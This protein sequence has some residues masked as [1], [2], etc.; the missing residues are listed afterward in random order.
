MKELTKVFDGN[1]LRVDM[2]NDKEFYIDVT[3]IARKYGKDITGWIRSK[4]TVEYMSELLTENPARTLIKTEARGSTKIHNKMLIPFARFISAKFAVWADNMI[5]DIITGNL[6][7]KYQCE[8]QEALA[9]SRACNVYVKNGVKFTSC[10]GLLQNVP[11][12]AN[13]Y[14]E[15]S[16]KDLLFAKGLI[17][18]IYQQTKRWRITDKGKKTDLFDLDSHGTILYNI[19]NTTK[20]INQLVIAESIRENSQIKKISVY[21][22]FTGDFYC[23]FDSLNEAERQLGVTGI[24]GVLNGKRQKKH[25]RGMV[26]RDDEPKDKIKPLSGDDLKKIF[27]DINV[28]KNGIFIK[29]CKTLK[30]AGSI[31]GNG[32]TQVKRLIDSGKANQ[33]GYTYAYANLEFSRR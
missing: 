7:D 30:E 14:D 25:I 5:Y 16:I 13:K 2:I 31:G 19:D 33:S 20:A 4:G 10:K 11:E 22:G 27:R 8:M 3:G 15:K 28:F 21:N 9:K 12:L 26:F 32:T 18:P 23:Q 1:E 24:S 17:E 29:R 6:A